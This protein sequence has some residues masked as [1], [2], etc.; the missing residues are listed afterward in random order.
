MS[1]TFARL[2]IDSDLRERSAILK[3]SRRIIDDGLFKI[4][5]DYWELHKSLNLP[6]DTIIRST[7]YDINTDCQCFLVCSPHLPSIAL[8]ECYPYILPHLAYEQ[9]EDNTNIAIWTWED[10][11]DPEARSEFNK[12]L[13]LVFDTVTDTHKLGA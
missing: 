13:G 5:Y 2:G 10:L 1:L 7:F 8:G 11:L 6:D 12:K 4:N 9:A 3:I